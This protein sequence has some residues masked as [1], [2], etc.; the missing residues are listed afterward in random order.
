MF[1]K[2]IY[3]DGFFGFIKDVCKSLHLPDVIQPTFYIIHPEHTTVSQEIKENLFNLIQI[4]SRLVF[5]L[6]AKSEENNVFIS[7]YC[8]I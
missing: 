4:I 8:V 7:L 2:H 6:L 3:S 5:H 1:E